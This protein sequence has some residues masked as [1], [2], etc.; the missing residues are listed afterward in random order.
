MDEEHTDCISFEGFM[1][2]SMTPA[3]EGEQVMHG[4]RT[5]LASESLVMDFDAG[6]RA[7][8]LTVPA[9]VL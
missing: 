4:I 2:F 7:A 5:L 6:K 1:N 3:T 8:E 9:V